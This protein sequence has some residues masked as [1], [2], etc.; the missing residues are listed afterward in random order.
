MIV[1][2]VLQLSINGIGFGTDGRHRQCKVQT[3]VQEVVKEHGRQN[4]QGEGTVCFLSLHL[5]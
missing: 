4:T 5:N 3:R 1:K 2:A